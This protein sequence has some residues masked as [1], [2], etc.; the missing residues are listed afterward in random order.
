MMWCSSHFHS[1]LH[2]SRLGRGTLP[3]NMVP[4]SCGREAS[5]AVR[6]ALDERWPTAG[7]RTHHFLHYS[8]GML[9]KLVFVS[10]DFNVNSFCGADGVVVFLS[11]SPVRSRRCPASQPPQLALRGSSLVTGTINF[12]SVRCTPWQITLRMLICKNNTLK[13]DF[14]S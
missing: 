2:P 12:T 5:Q 7:G 13:R 10:Y 11:I 3:R 14:C 6:Q 1:K 4:D 9:F 8:W